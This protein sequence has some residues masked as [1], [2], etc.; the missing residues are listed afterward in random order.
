MPFEA[1]PQFSPKSESLP[2]QIALQQQVKFELDLL[3][4]ELADT[5]N[6]IFDTQPEKY[7]TLQDQLRAVQRVRDIREGR[8]L[9]TS[10]LVQGFHA[11][12]YGKQIERAT[13]EIVEALSHRSNILGS[14]ATAE[15]FALERSPNI[16]VKKI[17][18]FD[19]YQN[20]NNLKQET[21]FL[22]LLEGVEVNGVRTPH[23]YFY[24][25]AA[26]Y[27]AYA[28]ERLDAMDTSLVITR[29]HQFQDEERLDP[30]AFVKSLIKYIE[31]MHTLGIVHCDIAARNVMID[32]KTL[33]PRVID[34][35]RAKFLANET[36]DDQQRLKEKDLHNAK[37]IGD[38]LVDFKKGK[39]FRV[40]FDA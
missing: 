9:R 31:H 35:G 19:K 10:E 11:Q 14:G 24:V 22:E 12:D 32:K 15:V 4:E 27:T 5:W 23:F 26:V 16:C 25:P 40:G 39:R 36:Y 17:Y 38:D 34:F 13:Q 6:T 29:Q 8:T 2:N 20:G 1:F 21:S 37:K 7:P 30:D 33:M 18:D 28:M 3:P